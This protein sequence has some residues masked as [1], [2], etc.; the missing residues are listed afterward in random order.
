LTRLRE[1]A[2]ISLA[3]GG[4][5]MVIAAS[6]VIAGIAAAAC[7]LGVCALGHRLLNRSEG[8]NAHCSAGPGQNIRTKLAPL[9]LSAIAC[10]LGMALVLSLTPSP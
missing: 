9:L 8:T 3:F 1:S 6:I 5:A 7:G 10:G 2:T 4:N